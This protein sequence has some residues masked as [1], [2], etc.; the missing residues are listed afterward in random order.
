M[1]RFLEEIYEQP[2]VIESVLDF[3]SGGAGNDLLDK[4]ARIVSNNK[5]EQVI[6]TGM[7]SSYFISHSASTLFNELGISSFV[8]NGSELLHYNLRLFERETLLICISQSGESYEIR[9][10]MAKLNPKVHCIGIVNDEESTLAGKA[11]VSLPAKAGREEKTSTK[12]YA[13]TSLVSF[14]LGWYLAGSW[15]EEKRTK[16][17]SLSDKFRSALSNYLSEINSVIK[18]LGDISTLQIIARGPAFSTASQSALMFKEALHLPATGMLGGEFRH[19]PMEMVSDG[20]K[21]ILFAAEGKTMLQS[22]KMAEDISKFGGKVV[23]ITNQK[24]EKHAN[25]I[26]QI[27]INEPD[28]YLFSVLSIVPVQLFVDSYAK[29]K[30][31]EAGSFS[32]GAKVTEIE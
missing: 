22:I 3:Y 24:L 20:F 11:G 28:E 21:S 29:S 7:G 10:I 1:N 19:G 23:L 31:F 26:Q 12:T 16:I 9:E 25:N 8:M 17:K 15:N 6:F 27:F 2:D 4:A 18:F 5:I 14:I 32:R 13:A 30:G